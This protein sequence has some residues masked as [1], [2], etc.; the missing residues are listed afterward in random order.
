[1]ATIDK[2]TPEQ[3]IELTSFYAEM[4]AVG[5][6]IEPI[7]HAECE[8]VI[9]D[10]YSRLDP[11]LLPA[12]KFLYFPSPKACFK[13][14]IDVLGFN[15]LEAVGQY[16]SGQQWVY[17]KALYTFGERIGVK[18]AEEQSDLL[19]LWMRESRGLHWW[20]PFDG[21]VLVSERPT[22][23]QLNDKGELHC[24]NGPAFE[25]S[26]GWNGF[27]LNGIHVPETLV[28]T[29]AEHLDMEFFKTEKNADVRTEF[30][31]KFGIE[32]MVDQG[33]LKDSYKNYPADKFPFWHKSAY[34]LWDMTALFPGLDYQP[35]L[36]ML[37]QT[38]DIWHMEALSPDAT[39]LDKA[40]D[41]RF[42]GRRLDIVGLA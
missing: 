22:I 12:P 16:F 24:E 7:D 23:L 1:M 4:L 35:Y 2:L 9:T 30:V 37:N 38:T 14:K 19:R 34:E 15:K 3:E 20:A 29:A 10:L 18:Y 8:A 25:Y 39:T 42:G 41:E 5:R 6:S 31:R 33:K 27:Y 26:D 13:Y 17:W 11:P 36:K 40:I 32:R 21:V 28:M